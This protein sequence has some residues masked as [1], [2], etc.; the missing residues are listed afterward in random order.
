MDDTGHEALA[1]GHP[2]YKLGGCAITV[3][4]LKRVI[5]DP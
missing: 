4:D 2:I 5:C 1:S 3:A